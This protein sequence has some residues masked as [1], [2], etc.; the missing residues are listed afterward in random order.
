MKTIK[1]TKIVEASQKGYFTCPFCKETMLASV[2]SGKDC[3][4]LF[5]KDSH[6]KAEFVLKKKV[7]KR[8][9]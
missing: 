6:G 4:H 2:Y 8:H 9:I 1:K 5:W 3:P 7:E